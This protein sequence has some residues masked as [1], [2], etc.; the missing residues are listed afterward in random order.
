MRFVFFAII[1]TQMSYSFSV[2][3]LIYAQYMNP[4]RQNITNHGTSIL[5]NVS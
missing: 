1:P 2:P 5:C 4:M 3:D